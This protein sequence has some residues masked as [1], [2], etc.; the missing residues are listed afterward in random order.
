MKTAFG[1]A[2]VLALCVLTNSSH[3]RRWG[4]VRGN[5]TSQKPRATSPG[6][7]SRDLGGMPRG[8]ASYPGAEAR[9]SFNTCDANVQISDATVLQEPR[10]PYLPSRW[11]FGRRRIR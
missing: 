8:N 5:T 3:A 10:G 9:W 11:P 1:V 4:D 6:T 2:V 7:T